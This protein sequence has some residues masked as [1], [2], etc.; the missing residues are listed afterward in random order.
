MLL[1]NTVCRDDVKCAHG[2]SMYI[3]TQNHKILFDMGPNAMFLENAE[4]LG[5]N[6]ADVDIAVLSHAHNDHCGGLELF[7]K[8]NDH[9]KIYLQQEVWGEYY[10]V[11]PSK[12][13]YIGLDKALKKYAG[14]F[15]LV[16]GRT[17]IDAELQLFSGGMGRDYWSHAN[18]T[19][20]KKVGEE[21]P[22][23]EFR[24]EQNLIVT[25]NGKAVLF[26]GCAHNGVVNIL[27]RAEELLGRAPD[28]VFAGFHLFNPSLGKAEPRE[29][30]DAVAAE[31]KAREGTHY[32]TG[33]CTGEEAF[34]ELKETLGDQLTYMSGGATFEV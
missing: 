34:A 7:C 14:R 6:I 15:T 27:R 24:H 22:K 29:L 5:V 20:R 19:L 16:S 25:E 8:R 30:V 23:D 13:A 17:V 11:T 9:A 4:T 21:F 1:E 2:L 33:H 32:Y 31:L 12:C 3:E 10:V 28:A 26:G 18:D